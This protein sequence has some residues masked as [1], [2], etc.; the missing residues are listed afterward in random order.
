MSDMHDPLNRGICVARR[1]F[2]TGLALGTSFAG[3]G[4]GGRLLA[5]SMKQQGPQTLT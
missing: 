1:R 2:V 3:L 4:F 5:A